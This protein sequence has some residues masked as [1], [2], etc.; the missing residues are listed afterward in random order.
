[1][2]M[3]RKKFSINFTEA[4]TKFSLSLHHNSDDSYLFVNGK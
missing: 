4:N 3:T 2:W 1:M